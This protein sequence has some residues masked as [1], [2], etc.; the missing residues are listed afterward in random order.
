M[1]LKIRNRIFR[2]ILQF[3]KYFD[4]YSIMKLRNY[5]YKFILS[6]IG[7][8][9]NICA[10]VTLISP[11]NIEIGDKVSIHHNC[12]IGG[13]GKI[14]IGN[15]VS[16]ANGSIIIS[17]EHN[18]KNLEKRIKDQGITKKNIIIEDNVWIGANVKILGGVTIKTGSIVAAGAV[19]NTDT[20][21]NSIFGGVPAKFIKNR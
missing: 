20:F 7:D 19:V 17:E 21:E 15:Y 16:I 11:E 3:I 18:Y 5:L 8:N 9:C 4:F 13:K 2:I 10:A 14:K 6:K 1:V 12:Y